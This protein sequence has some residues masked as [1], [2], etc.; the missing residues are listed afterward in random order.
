[1]RTLWRNAHLTTLAEANGWGFIRRGALVVDDDILR[2]V[3][4]DADLPAGLTVD[5]EHHLDGEVTPGRADCHTHLVYGGQRAREPSCASKAPATK[6]SPTPAAASADR[7]RHPRRQRRRPFYAA[8]LRALAL[9]AEGVTSL[10]IK[11]GHGLSALHEARCPG[12][13]PA[14]RGAA[15]DG[16]HHLPVGT[17]PA[18]GVRGPTR[19]LHRGGLRL[20][21]PA[22][23]GAAD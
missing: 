12:R 7:R 4:S 14:R 15:P 23:R 10:E 9:M 13:P 20:A 11:S 2:W 6:T 3:G 1:M 5:A 22:A 19:R 8:R 18:A 16:A 21:A 17:R